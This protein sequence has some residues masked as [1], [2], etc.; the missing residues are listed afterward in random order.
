MI[1]PSQQ[2]EE[3]S[4]LAWIATNFQKH[5]GYLSKNVGSFDLIIGTLSGPRN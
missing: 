5:F 1:V 2:S 4:S 3:E